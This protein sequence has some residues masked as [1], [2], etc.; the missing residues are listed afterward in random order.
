MVQTFGAFME[1]CYLARRSVLTDNSLAQLE[2]AIASFHEHRKIFVEKSVRPDGFAS[3]MRQH[4]VDHYPQH[5]RQFGAPNGLCSSITESKH[6]KAVKEPWRRSSRYE[7]L[8]QMLLTNQRLDKLAASRVDFQERGLL[9][10]SLLYATIQ[11]FEQAA[12][13]AAMREAAV[14]AAT[15]ASARL[16]DVAPVPLP[17]PLPSN[18]VEEEEE[19]AVEGPRTQSSVEL[20]KRSAAGYPKMMSGL[21][22]YIDIPELPELVA[23][24]I[25]DQ[26]NP[27]AP[28]DDNMEI[29]EE[30][31]EDRRVSVA[32]SAVATYYAPSDLSGV[33]GMH[34][35]R[36]RATRS[37][38]NGPA[39]YDCVA[40]VTDASADG[41][42][43]LT[44]GRVRLFF[45]F[46]SFGVRYPC[47]LVEW[48]E[49]VGAEPDE[50]TGMWVVAPEYHH[51]GSRVRNV[52]HLDTI[53]RNVHLLPTFGATYVPRGLDFTS[54]L[55]AF[56]AFYVS[57]YADHHSHEILF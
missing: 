36:I 20:A 28:L 3:L 7:A 48:F 49:K 57:K 6:I 14:R 5:I 35:E 46:R 18:P 23:R 47:A 33:G 27:D 37:W 54:S 56:R 50:I 16:A 26:H 1:F 30:Y 34:R 8:G 44:V 2:A 32:N 17:Q 40:A 51:D 25:H 43:G 41:M 55:D 38:R 15:V 13:E 22:E 12:T 4:A 29:P 21:A 39:R 19:E 11:A 42:R 45:S 24:F 52:V 9:V 31:V 53:L 10:G